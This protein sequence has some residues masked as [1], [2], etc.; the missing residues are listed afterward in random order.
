M[1]GAD[2]DNTTEALDPAGLKEGET[3]SD[4]WPGSDT[5]G[6]G[7]ADGSLCTIL[8][9]LGRPVAALV[10][11]IVTAAVG[12]DGGM[13][14]TGDDK[15]GMLL[16]LK[17]GMV[18]KPDKAAGSIAGLVVWTVVARI[19]GDTANELEVDV[20]S[21]RAAGGT[22]PLECA[23]EAALTAAAT[24]SLA[25]LRLTSSTI[26][27]RPSLRI[28]FCH[29]VLICFK[30]RD[31]TAAESAAQSRP[32][33]DRAASNASFSACVQCNTVGRSLSGLASDTDE[34]RARTR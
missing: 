29:H 3:M 17:E 19:D 21:E 10:I 27:F 26:S 13:T 32:C 6:N 33:S 9:A 2:G 4:D 18:G 23:C 7:A 16:L 34:R 11:G 12:R 25:F 8:S 24:D 15:L 14:S 30:V 20:G 1:R 22:A 5:N 28:L 31:G